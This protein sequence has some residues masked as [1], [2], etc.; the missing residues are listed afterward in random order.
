MWQRSNY[1]E[2]AQRIGKEFSDNRGNNTVS[3]NQL[4]TKV[5]R[6]NNLN[7]EGIRTMVRLA[8][9]AV[10]EEIFHKQAGDK[11][12]EFEVG[13]P[14]VVINTLYQET[15]IAMDGMANTPTNYNFD[16]DYYGDFV[17]EK[18]PVQSIKIAE[19]LP[20]ESVYISPV[21][22]KQRCMQA[23]EKI[24][25]EEKEHAV[26]WIDALEK[27]AKLF[28]VLSPSTPE[29]IT[30]EKDALAIIGEKAVPELTVF[31]ELTGKCTKYALLGGK[32]V[33]EVLDKHIANPSIPSQSI[34]HMLK[35]AQNARE[36]V[37][38]CKQGLKWLAQ[39]STRIK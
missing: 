12:F 23:Q 36:Q 10:F 16:A 19:V 8:N 33:N 18:A 31:R 26:E 7:P 2:A 5:A 15:K 27:A 3:I 9:V 11:M 13:D 24:A 14:E 34:I 21:A 29:S 4:A 35:E 1:E 20:E 22:I 38:V 39:N 25:M 17:N 30:L 37:A 6:D 28:N 32:S